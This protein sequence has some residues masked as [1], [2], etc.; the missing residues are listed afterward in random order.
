MLL[1]S[2]EVLGITDGAPPPWLIN[3][4]RHGP[5]PS[6]PHLKIPELNAPLKH[7][8]WGDLEVE[9]EKEQQ[10]IEEEELENGIQSVDNLSSTPT[11][12]ETPEDV[13]DLRKRKEH[14]RPPLYQVLEEKQERIAPGTLFGTTHTYI[15]LQPKELEA[16]DNI[17]PAKYE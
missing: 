14:E 2:K 3:M 5:P 9:E 8:H 16:M 4:Q 15:T 13:I 7:K 1:K 10:Q 17:L 12:D 11:G 6:Y